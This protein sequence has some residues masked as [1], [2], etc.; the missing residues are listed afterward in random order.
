M[1]IVKSI[2]GRGLSAKLALT[3]L[4]LI[5]A[6]HIFASYAFIAHNRAILRQAT[7][8]DIIQKIINTI[9]L[10]QATPELNRQHAIEA[11]EDPDIH[12][13]FSESPQFEI[14]FHEL[15]LWAINETLHNNYGDFAISL[16]MAPNQ[17]LNISANVYSHFLSTQILLITFEIIVFAAI[18]FS[19]WSINRFTGPL[20]SFKSAAEN[21]G[22]DLHAKPLSIYGPSIVRETAE[23]INTMQQR[24]QELI[25]NRTL[26]LAAISHDLRTPITR[27]KLRT[28]FITD[29]ATRNKFDADLNEMETM[30]AQ[31]LDFARDDSKIEKLTTLDLH[32]FLQSICD[33]MQDMGHH[34]TFHTKAQQVP[35]NGGRISLKRAITNLI[36][37]ALK[38]GN[39]VNVSLKKHIKSIVISIEDNGPGIRE[40]DLD[41]VLQPFYRGDLS[42]SKHTGGVGL[43]LAVTQDIIKKHGGDI[44]LKNLNTG[45]LQVLIKLPVA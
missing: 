1:T 18:L 32:S 40:Q 4:T 16:E 23:A 21:L 14:Q 38:Y 11:F 39:Q 10:V 12:T 33:E 25:R 44:T 41:K 20:K 19:A 2:I 31:T 26:M 27:I 42:R 36:T 30:I 34:V 45:G 29:E 24:I 9:H 15:S 7:R 3:A 17:W 5:V 8:D 28:H 37:N 43:G 22:M 6:I 13:N 35:F